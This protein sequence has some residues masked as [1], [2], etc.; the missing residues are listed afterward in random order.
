[1]V[2][3]RKN[4]NSKNRQFTEAVRSHL[5]QEVPTTSQR[6]RKK[7][8][9]DYYVDEDLIEDALLRLQAIHGALIHHTNAVIETAEWIF[10][11]TQHISTIPY[12]YA[13]LAPFFFLIQ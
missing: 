11:F 12:K 8:E 5:S 13:T 2:W 7:K 6:T 10:N 9:Q 3:M 4:R 1:M